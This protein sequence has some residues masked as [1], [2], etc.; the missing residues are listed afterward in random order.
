MPTRR[1]TLLLTLILGLS[2]F[3]ASH[4]GAMFA[5]EEKTPP[6]SPAATADPFAVPD[7]PP[8]D[9]LNFA[10][11][12]L[13]KR[14]LGESPD[15]AKAAIGA[16]VG[17]ILK[18]KTTENQ[19]RFALQYRVLAAY[20]PKEILAF[21]DELKTSGTKSDLRYVTSLYLSAQIANNLNSRNPAD[22]AITRD[23]AMQFLKEATVRAS[24]IP[25]ASAFA[26]ASETLDAPTD[27]AKT[28]AAIRDIF[29]AG[30]EDALTQFAGVLDASIRRANAFGSKPT[31]EGKLLT[32][33]TL[34]LDDYKGRVV[35]V[36]F[37]ATWCG[38]CLAEIPNLERV[39]AK[40][41]N[42]GFEILSFSLDQ[43]RGALEAFVANR[44]IPWPIVYGDNGPSPS[45]AYYGV[46]SIPYMLLLDKN[47][48]VVNLN[49]SGSELDS[50]LEKLLTPDQ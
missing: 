6:P 50:L 19:R 14:M 35:L 10:R 18:S 48:N 1:N 45:V 23:K 13:L 33:Q 2:A 24:D 16:A 44:G 30:K 43:D 28:F 42:R 34:K 17:R 26:A 29:A 47:G 22:W 38:P 31:L 32:G 36:D 7:A 20:D 8:A 9:L 5:V 4:D 15:K 46:S 11:A 3:L 40:Y 25:L 21:A 49:V 12:M 39:Y 37:W 27:A 41:K